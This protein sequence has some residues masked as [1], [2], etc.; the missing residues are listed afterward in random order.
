M[1]FEKWNE[2]E[3]G[4]FIIDEER[5]VND[6]QV[7]TN[8][9]FS[10][11]WKVYSKEEISEQEKLFK[12]QREWFLDLYGFDD[13][14]HL[15]KHLR[16][17]KYILDAGC[18]LGY[19][20][21]WFASLAPN[22]KIIGIDFSSASYIA[23]QRYK[24]EFPNLLFAKGDIA[25]TLL[26]SDSTGFTVCD[27]VIMH[28]DN[29]RLTLSELS[30]ITS[31]KGEV[32]CYWYRKKALPRE[33]LDDY[34][35]VN[36]SEFSKEE[37]WELSREVLELGKMLSNLKVEAN[38][39]N[40][41]SLGIVGGK[42]DLQRFIYWNFLKCFWNKEL[43]YATSLNTNFDWYSPVNAKRFTQ[44]EIEEN[45]K[46]AKLKKVFWHEEKACFSGRFK[47]L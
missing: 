23:Y 5:S 42:M 13:E 29:P 34:F 26:P 20:A 27:Q 17:F 35:R 37:L 6:A 41:P 45:L 21:A 18:G 24:D 43:G 1:N 15:A 10:E 46:N 25:K 38:F 44:T 7:L 32:C 28:T 12:F 47:K 4:F 30:R 22:S 39:P 11:K 19:K 8:D 36:T 9:A 31:N 14:Q 3:P 40:L 2:I 33:L 16:N